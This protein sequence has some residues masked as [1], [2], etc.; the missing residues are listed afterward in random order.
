MTIRNLT[1]GRAYRFKV[2][3]TNFNQEGPESDSSL[4]FACQQPL[5]L[6][7]PIHIKSSASSMTL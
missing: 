5:G 1:V 6:D 3:A 7:P 4:F 2:V